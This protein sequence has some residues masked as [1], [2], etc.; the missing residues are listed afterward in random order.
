VVEAAVA[1]AEDQ[2]GVLAAAASDLEE[3]DNPAVLSNITNIV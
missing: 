2:Q 1:L 3:E